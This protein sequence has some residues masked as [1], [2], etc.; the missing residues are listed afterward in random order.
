M[1]YTQFCAMLYIVILNF[2]EKNT[3]ATI[4]FSATRMQL[5]SEGATYSGAVFNFATGVY[6]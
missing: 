2:L 5:C 4:S 1:H 3:I 6:V